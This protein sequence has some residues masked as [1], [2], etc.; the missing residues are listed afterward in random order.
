[1]GPLVLQYLYRCGQRQKEEISFGGVPGE[2][3][4]LWRS[5]IIKSKGKDLKYNS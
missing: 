2:E 5:K 4:Q 1:M 3:T